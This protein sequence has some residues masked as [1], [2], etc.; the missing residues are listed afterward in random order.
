MTNT[1]DITLRPGCAIRKMRQDKGWTIKQL[2]EKSGVHHNQVA[3]IEL[4][5]AG[6]WFTIVSIFQALGVDVAL[7][8]KNEKADSFGGA[9]DLLNAAHASVPKITRRE[10]PPQFFGN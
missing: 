9:L 2:A 5:N 10:G 7:D 8:F 6:G 3:R 4:K 1:I